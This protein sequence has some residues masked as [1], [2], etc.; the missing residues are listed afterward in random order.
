MLWQSVD[1]DNVPGVPN[2]PCC[3]HVVTDEDGHL[4]ENEDESDRELC[5][6]WHT[7]FQARA[8]GTRHLQ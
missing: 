3:L 2:K 6:Y 8:E 7:I 4:L 5:D 1:L